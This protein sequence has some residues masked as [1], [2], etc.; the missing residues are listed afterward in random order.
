MIAAF[1][2]KESDLGK[3]EEINERWQFDKPYLWGALLGLVFLS[4][5]LIFELLFSDGVQLD[6]IWPYGLIPIVGFSVIFG[7]TAKDRRRRRDEMRGH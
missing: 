4:F 1:G 6:D 5:S 2:P 7:I 3:F